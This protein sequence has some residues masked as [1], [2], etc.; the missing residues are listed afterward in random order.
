[1]TVL[2]LSGLIP[3]GKTVAQ[4][5]VM[6]VDSSG[7]IEPSPDQP[8][9]GGAKAGAN[10]DDDNIIKVPKE[11]DPPPPKQFTSREIQAVCAKYKNNLV[12]VY[13]ELYRIKNCTRHLVLNQDDIFRF[14]RQGIKT[15]EVEATDVAAL[16][17]GDTWE[18]VSTKDR[19]CTFFSKKYVTFSYTDIYFVENCVRKLVPDYETLLSHR[20]AQG[21]KSTEVLALTAREFYGIRQGRDITS[22]VDKEFSK[23]LDGSAGV[24]IIPIDEA[25]KGVDGKIVTFYSRMY[26]IEKCRKREINAEK[27]TM[28][29][30][31]N[32][33]KL[34]ELRPEQWVSMPDG[35]PFDPK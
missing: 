7:V 34:I 31:I 12:S 16:P 14:A 28:G 1:M 11:P 25:C 18:H 32:D 9:A 13:G 17:V 3:S 33:A 27:F 35:K 10:E 20:K 8:M 23:L 6:P 21:I 5:E 4:D 22:I 26:K 19:P 15:V 24:D 29:R 30:R 2:V